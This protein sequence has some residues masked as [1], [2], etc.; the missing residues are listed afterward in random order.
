MRRFLL[1]AFVLATVL[2]TS[3]VAAADVFTAPTLSQARKAAQ[4]DERLVV[5]YLYANDDA[6]SSFMER[7]AWNHPDVRQ[8]VDS[9]GVAARVDAFSGHGATLRGTY[10][11][12]TLPAVLAFR[13][14]DLARKHQGALDGRQLYAWLEVVRVGDVEMADLILD[15]APPSTE[16]NGVDI[17]GRL[18]KAFDAKTP[19]AAAAELLSVWTETIGTDQQEERRQ[20]I[21]EA[22]KDRVANDVTARERTYAARDASWSRYQK[23]EK[24]ADLVDWLVLNSVLR[25]DH[26]TMDWLGEARKTDG[27][28]LAAVLSHPQDPLLPMLAESR[29][30]STVGNIIANPIALIDARQ[31]T[32]QATKITITGAESSADRNAHHRAWGV[33]VTGLL[34]A[35]REREARATAEHAI[36]ID[37]K[38]APAIVDVCIEA[39]QPRRWQ[40]GMLDPTRKDQVDLAMRLNRALQGL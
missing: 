30:W 2:A 1:S 9:H 38:A 28:R 8:W 22:L 24:V 25:E 12:E 6:D 18:M 35:N 37:R 11:I 39:G 36:S 33:L 26:V 23:R 17:E 19:A 34:A 27:P 5:V 40:R 29:A 21:A 16:L 7:E 20:P 15:S 13:G 31:A 14:D 32:Y 3:P 10:Q 4:G